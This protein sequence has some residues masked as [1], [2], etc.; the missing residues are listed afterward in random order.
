MIEFIL[1]NPDSEYGDSSSQNNMNVDQY[2]KIKPDW[3][4]AL[5]DT[6][7]NFHPLSISQNSRLNPFGFIDFILPQ[8]T[9]IEQR[10][11]NKQFAILKT[12]GDWTPTF[13]I[14]EPKDNI[15]YFSALGLLPEPFSSYYPLTNSPMF[16]NGD[17]NQQEEL[18]NFI[19]LNPNDITPDESYPDIKNIEFNTSQLILS[20]T[21]QVK[22]GN[23]LI[24][25][26]RKPS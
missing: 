6:T 7:L 26:L 13:F 3:E 1:Q 16:I 25:F 9:E 21:E 17:I 8:L 15:T 18:Y 4:P 2:L 22:L 24:E 23:E 20:L 19:R 14:F 12:T 5:E 10:L 11:K